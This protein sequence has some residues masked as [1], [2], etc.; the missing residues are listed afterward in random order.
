MTTRDHIQPTQSHCWNNSL[1]FRT[2]SSLSLLFSLF[3]CILR[4]Q[5]IVPLHFLSLYFNPFSNSISHSFAVHF[6]TLVNLYFFSLFL[7]HFFSP[8]LAR[9]FHFISLI[10]IVLYFIALFCL[11]AFSLWLLS[12][13]Y[14]Y[15]LFLFYQSTFLFYLLTHFLN[16]RETERES[17]WRK[18]NI[19]WSESIET[20]SNEKNVK[21]KNRDRKIERG[22]REKKWKET[23]S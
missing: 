12:P 3:T 9:I 6:L 19:K 2:L 21:K 15:F 22:N 23:W 16:K 10:T 5:T 14:H 8:F 20:E 11:S 1:Y 17:A 7:I 18:W 13:L 4:S